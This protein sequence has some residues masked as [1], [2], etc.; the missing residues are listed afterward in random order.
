MPKCGTR[1][2]LTLGFVDDTVPGALIST[3]R[4][5]LYHITA[6]DNIHIFQG[7][8]FN[9]RLLSLVPN[10]KAILARLLEQDSDTTK[11][12]MSANT[13]LSGECGALW[14]VAN[15]LHWDDGPVCE[16]FYQG[17]RLA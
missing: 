13:E 8:D 3:T 10:L 4:P 9:P 12:G 15:H 11:V 16:L 6:I 7:R 14:R 5:S 2:P 17:G 1:Q